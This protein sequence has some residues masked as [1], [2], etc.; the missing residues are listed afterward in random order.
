[1][2]K[3]TNIRNTYYQAVVKS[4]GWCIP[5]N[6]GFYTTSHNAELACKKWIDKHYPDNTDSCCYSI[7]IFVYKIG[8]EDN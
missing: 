6:L 4:G 1:M 8:Q 7:R 3:F 5:H 2:S